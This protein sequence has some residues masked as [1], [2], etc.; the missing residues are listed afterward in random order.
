MKKLFYFL[1]FSLACHI[2]SAHNTNNC[3]QRDQP[4]PILTGGLTGRAILTLE[5]IDTLG[6]IDTTYGTYCR[7][8]GEDSHGFK[9]ISMECSQIVES[10]NG[11]LLQ[12][13]QIDATLD[14][15]PHPGCH[16][17]CGCYRSYITQLNEVISCGPIQPDYHPPHCED[18]LPGI[19]PANC[20]N[21]PNW[22]G[23][24]KVTH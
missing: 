2:A 8:R 10:C 20:E 5:S 24:Q 17:I 6:S 13:A 12:G 22:P 19:V 1:T 3:D 21:G 7:F 9:Y 4:P 18:Y 11:N 15:G 14:W 16:I 23:N